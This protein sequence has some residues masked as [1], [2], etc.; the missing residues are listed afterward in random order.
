LAAIAVI[1]TGLNYF[2]MREMKQEEVEINR[3]E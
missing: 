1:A 3:V 2:L